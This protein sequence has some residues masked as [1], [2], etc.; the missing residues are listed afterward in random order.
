MILLQL[1]DIT[2]TKTLRLPEVPLIIKD[3]VIDVKNRTIGNNLRVFIYPNS[4]KLT[5]SHTWAFM[6]INDYQTIRDFRDRQRS[7]GVFPEL[8][9]TG[10]DSGDIIDLPVYITF[11]EKRIADNCETVEKQSVVFEG[12]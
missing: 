1:K 6:P 10:L 9:I 5:I 7:S 11:D 8:S 12:A 3:D 2:E 4:D